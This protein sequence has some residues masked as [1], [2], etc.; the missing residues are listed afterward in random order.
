[1]M[2]TSERGFKIVEEIK[3]LMSHS[4]ERYL[5]VGCVTLSDID[6]VTI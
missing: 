3:F 5:G 1:M 6:T 4:L 2:E